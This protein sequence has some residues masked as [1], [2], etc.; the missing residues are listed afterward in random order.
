M[1]LKIRLTLE[2][3]KKMA[4]NSGKVFLIKKVKYGLDKTQAVSNLTEYK[5]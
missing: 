3:I 1:N 5:M 4:E 2:N